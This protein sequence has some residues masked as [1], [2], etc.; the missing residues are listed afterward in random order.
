M[1]FF[2][3]CREEIAKD[4]AKLAEESITWAG[5]FYKIPCPHL[6]NA[7]IGKNWWEIH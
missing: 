7:Q 5:E 2:V 4:V 3:E 1:V 6:G